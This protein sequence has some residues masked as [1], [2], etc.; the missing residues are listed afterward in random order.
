MAVYIIRKLK[1]LEKV[2]KDTIES[3]WENTSVSEI[4]KVGNQNRI[5]FTVS[6]KTAM[7][8]IFQRQDGT[9]TF[10]SI[11]KNTELTNLLIEE[12][13]KRGYPV[14]SDVKSFS[15][16][17]GNEWIKKTIDYLIR[18]TTNDNNYGFYKSKIN[19]GNTIHSFTSAIGDKLTLTEC[20]DGKL[21][22]QGK[23][24]YLYNEFLSFV[25]YS[26]NVNIDEIVAATKTFV[27][28]GVKDASS[29]RAKMVSLMPKAYSSGVIDETIWKVFSPSMALIDVDSSME[30]Y[31][32]VM[33]PAL[34]ALEGY[35]LLLLSEIGEVI[36]QHHLIGNIFRVDPTDA[37]KFIMNKR[38]AI[39]NANRTGP[40][41]KTALEEIYTY[42]NKHRHVSFH[43][44]QIVID[45]K[46]ISNK[47]E[48]IDTVN[49]VSQLIER[50]F[51]VTHP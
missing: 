42:F 9:T 35:L 7:L 14:T 8:A 48:A 32:C 26:P 25:S 23:P 38:A 4:T 17:V 24:L 33:F 39:A 30:D 11:G 50:T 27:N 43:M 40:Q 21:L 28:C 15:M 44:S 29:A 13:E 22:V 16:F 47:Q 5:S 37:N 18:L 19:N 36:D 46:V 3:L 6:G 34:R 45:T 2:I 12:L 20:S 41:Y 1:L 31:S 10:N 51:T 49:E